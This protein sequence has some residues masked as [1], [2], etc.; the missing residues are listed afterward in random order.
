MAVF[1]EMK[2]YLAVAGAIGLLSAP[3]EVLLPV[4][5]RLRRRT[6]IAIGP[7]SVIVANEALA[8]GALHRLRR[9]PEVWAALKGRRIAPWHLTVPLY[10]LLSPVV[11]TRWERAVVLRGRSALW[12]GVLSTSGLVQVALLAVTIARARRARRTAD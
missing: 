2:P 10:L 12:G 7:S 11:A 3:A 1:D 6:G 8:L 9:R 4:V 5:R